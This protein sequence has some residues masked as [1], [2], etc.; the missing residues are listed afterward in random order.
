MGNSGSGAIPEIYAVHVL[1]SGGSR[2]L[3]NNCT[4]REARPKIF[5]ATPT[6]D[7]QRHE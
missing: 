7:R 5:V 1:H 2:I 4:A 3:E 6:F